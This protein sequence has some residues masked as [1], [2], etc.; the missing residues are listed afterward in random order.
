MINRVRQRISLA[1]LYKLLE[2]FKR[3]CLHAEALNELILAV[4]QSGLVRKDIKVILDK[5]AD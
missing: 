1:V 4:F 2:K 3:N 5:L